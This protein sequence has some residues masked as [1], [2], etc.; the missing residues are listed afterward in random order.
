MAL[1]NPANLEPQAF[2]SVAR[3][4]RVDKT[5]ATLPAST[6]QSLFVVAGGRVEITA[7]VGEVTTIVQTQ[8]CNAKLVSTPTTGTAV[9]ICAVL[10]ISAD[11]AGC[12]YG[13]TGTF[14]DA[15]V[16]AAAGATVLPAKSVVAPIGII[17]L[18]TS[19]TNTGA[20]KWALW[21]RPLD[22]GATVVS[23]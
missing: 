17:K 4:F 15:M 10:D 8:A 16:G 13:I 5:S 6:V 23:A 3:G 9:D 11:E 22:E 7:I 21:Y 20:T 18:S 19:A 12:L 14:G 2:T 1:V